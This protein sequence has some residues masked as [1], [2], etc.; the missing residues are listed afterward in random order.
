MKRKTESYPIDFVVLWVDGSDPKWLAKKKKYQPEIDVNNT[1]ARYREWGTFKYWFRAVEKYA[2][3]VN[4]IYLVTDEQKP[5]WLN[6]DHPKLTIVDHKD[7]LEPQNLPTYNTSAIELNLHRIPNLSEHFVYFNDDVFL[8]NDV[9]PTDFFKNGKP[10]EIANINAATGMDGNQQ[11]AK[12]MFN[13]TLLIN[14]HFNK[15][16]VV[17]RH[18][19]KW[20]NL[21]YGSFNIRTLSQIIYPYFTGYKAQHISVPFLKSTFEKVWKEEHDLLEET[22]SHKFRHPNDVNQYIF[23]Q[24]QLCENEFYP[25][26]KNIGKLIKLEQTRSNDLLKILLK[27]KNHIVCLNDSSYMDEAKFQNLRSELIKYFSDKLPEESAFEKASI[28][29]KKEE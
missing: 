3:W 9:K 7:F 1:A 14:R 17:N 4:H 18:I 2:P 12:M 29:Q 10:V 6:V 5:E 13:D 8:I 24:W 28:S 25:R 27:S 15:N 20:L 21:K 22:S 19:T 11:F 26:S 16:T 23:I